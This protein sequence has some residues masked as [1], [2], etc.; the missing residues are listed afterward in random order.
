MRAI[1]LLAV[2]FA[3][4]AIAALEWEN[5]GFQFVAKPQE[6]QVVA[7]FKFRNS[8]SEPVDIRAVK[9]SCNCMVAEADRQT[10]APGEAGEIRVTIVFGDRTGR[11][12]HFVDVVSTD[13]RE[14]RVIL[15]VA[16]L[17]PKMLEVSPQAVNWEPGEPA[18]PKRVRVHINDE[19]V[20]T[21]L[22]VASSSECFSAAVEPIVGGRD[23]D[24]V[25]LPLD[26]GQP[27]RGVI[28]VTCD[29]PAENPKS[30]LIYA[31]FR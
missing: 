18:K 19:L 5:R 2:G 4:P 11:Q 22:T 26:R 3:T 17:I 27:A 8:G 16:G 29:A 31:G 7:L 10:Y 24:V 20:V 23:Y 21:R 1:L 25:I 12:D 15:H 9:P 13:D 28:R 6:T 30:A 14:P